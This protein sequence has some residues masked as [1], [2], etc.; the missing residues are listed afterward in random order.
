MSTFFFLIAITLQSQLHK[1]FSSLFILLCKICNIMKIN[2]AVKNNMKKER[3]MSNLASSFVF[4]LIIEYE[5]F[6]HC[7]GI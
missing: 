4:L 5:F 1:C 2:F 7:N 3:K 6:S